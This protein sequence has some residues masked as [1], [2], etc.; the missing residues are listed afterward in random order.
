MGN[1]LFS[2]DG[3]IGKADFTKGAVILLAANFVLWLAW[4]VNFGIGGL[5]GLMSLVLIYCWGCLFVK[6]FKAAGKSGAMF[7]LVFFVFL[8]LSYIL[9]NL[10][11]LSLSPDMVVKAEELQAL[12]QS[13]PE[14]IE[15]LLPLM[16]EL[17]G[18]MVVPYA[19]AYFIAGAFIAFVT[20]AKMNDNFA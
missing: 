15:A 17:M 12:S 13:D 5:A 10:L 18:A 9:A 4:L 14:N 7:V 11:M 1:L 20:N 16:N 8:F 6:R 2:P 3:T 19:V